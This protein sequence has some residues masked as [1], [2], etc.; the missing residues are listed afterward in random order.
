LG[1]F[2]SLKPWVV[3]K[4]LSG[5]K[6]WAVLGRPTGQPSIPSIQLIPDLGLFGI[7]SKSGTF[8]KRTQKWVFLEKVPKMGLFLYIRKC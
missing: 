6:P 2:Q 4:A 8:Y 7:D 5:F 1:G 3:S